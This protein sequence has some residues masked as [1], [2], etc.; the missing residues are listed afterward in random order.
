M[1]VGMTH[2]ETIPERNKKGYIFNMNNAIGKLTVYYVC[3]CNVIMACIISVLY[4]VHLYILENGTHKPGCSSMSQGSAQDT[5]CQGDQEHVSKVKGCLQ[6]SIHLG[7][8]K[9][10]VNSIDENIKSSRSSRSIGSPL[11]LIVLG[12]KTK[13]DNNDRCHTHDNGQDTIY[14]QQE[15]ID[16]VKLVVPQ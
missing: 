1:D 9:E 11:P 16:M 2:L 7:L 14:S 4:L 5:Q 12:I 3:C 8:E 10:V 15:T 6:E 13:V